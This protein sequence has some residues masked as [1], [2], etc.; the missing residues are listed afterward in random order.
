MV[1]AMVAVTL[2][3][4]C[5]V[6]ADEDPAPAAPNEATEGLLPEY[7]IKFGDTDDWLQ[8][9]TGEWLRGNLRW[10]RA[11]GI[12]AGENVMFYSEKLNDLTFDW[13]DIAQLHSP[14]IKSYTLRGK[15]NIAG[16]AMITK[17]QLIIETTEGL[18]TFPRGELVSIIEG[19]PRERSWW[20]T[21]F[22][23]GFSA[24]A[25]NTNQGSLNTTWSLQRADGRTLGA[26]SYNGN[27]GW[28]NGSVNA[29]RHLIDYDVDLFFWRRFYIIPVVGQLLYDEFQNIKLRATPGAGAGVHLF[30][31]RKERRAHTNKIQWDLQTALG[32]QFTRLFSAAT[33]V[34]NPQSAG[35]VMLRTYWNFSFVND[36]VKIEIDWRTNLVYTDIGSTNHN[37]TATITVQVTDM[38]DFVPSF[39]FL[40][41]EDPLPES[42]GT[43]PKKND[44]Q[45]VVSIALEFG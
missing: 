25:G 31:K 16:R 34:S 19:E 22:S 20:S 43:I 40:R 24:N 35:F 44:Y 37:G 2:W 36:D 15:G 38:I 26:I 29:N 30:D 7:T 41:T 33:G 27:V 4:P 28:A 18:R 23:L 45:L 8:L 42:D 13:S 6:R 3:S 12:Q 1:L 21:Q 14:K 11:K 17:N 9:N 39:L 5:P 32:Y 10:M